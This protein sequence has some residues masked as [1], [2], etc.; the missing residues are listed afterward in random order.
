MATSNRADWL[1]PAGLIALAFIPV[2][3]GML[4]F[5]LVIGGGPLTPDNA[6]FFAAPLP[7]LL[8][9]VSSVIYCIFGA[10]QFAPIFRRRHPALHRGAGR[11]LVPCGLLAA[12]SGLWMTQ[13]YPTGIEPPASFDGPSLRIIRLLAGSAMVLCLCLGFAAIRRR[14]IPR[15][16][17]WMM[18]G[19]ALGLSAGTQAF[20]HLPWFLFP[21]IHGELART[22]FMGAGWV[23]NLAV[24]EWLILRGYQ[25]K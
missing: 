13:F 17:A 25:R 21:S 23:I 19:Y 6:R 22:L 8:H 2:V 20:T 3:A 1:I 12:L 18:R 16:R 4:R 9:I 11:M 14:E 7:V 15:H 10:F 24:A 5:N